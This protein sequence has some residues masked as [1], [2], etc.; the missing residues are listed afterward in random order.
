M[1]LLR[2]RGAIPNTLSR[3]AGLGAWAGESRR[4]VLGYWLFCTQS[5]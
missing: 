5:I 4:A 1:R 2:M 3:N